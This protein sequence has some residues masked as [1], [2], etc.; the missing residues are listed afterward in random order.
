LI[1]VDIAILV[2]VSISALVSL[3]RGLIKEVLSLLAWVLAFWVAITF[4]DPFAGAFAGHI[5]TPSLRLVVAF[6]ILFIATLLV[7]G[8]VNFLIGKLVAKT[9]LSG[10]D[11]VL[12][13]VFGIVR[14]IAVVAILVLLAGLTRVP[15]DPWW[16]QSMFIHHFQTLATWVIGFLPDS[17]AA[18]FSYA[19]GPGEAG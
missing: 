14:G 3:L 10:T 17:L 2:I 8:L 11:R 19:S 5:E 1:W 12:G 7:A 15:Q 13:M 18:H 9:G 4:A 6:L 16:S